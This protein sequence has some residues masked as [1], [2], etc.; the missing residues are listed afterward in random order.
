MPLVQLLGRAVLT[1]VSIDMDL[2]AEAC[3][4][5]VLEDLQDLERKKQG[6][7]NQTMQGLICEGSKS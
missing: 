1:A 4:A 7:I 2:S 5:R 6:R 3:S